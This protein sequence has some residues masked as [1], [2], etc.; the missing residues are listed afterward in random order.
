V[1]ARPRVD[2]PA[3][4]RDVVSLVRRHNLAGIEHADD[5]LRMP[6]SAR[7]NQRPRFSSGTALPAPAS[8]HEKEERQ[9]ARDA[10]RAPV[11][12]DL[13]PLAF[14]H[15]ALAFLFPCFVSCSRIALADFAML[16][17]KEGFVGVLFRRASRLRRSSVRGRRGP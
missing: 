11:L 6:V 13:A 1:F 10:P 15:G 5:V 9:D 3:I 7:P 8:H 14:R 12:E 16:C 2:G 4:E 17:D